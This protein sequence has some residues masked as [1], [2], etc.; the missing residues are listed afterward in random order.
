MVRQEKVSME[1]GLVP[2]L[3]LVV[4]LVVVR[5]LSQGTFQEVQAVLAA[6]VFLLP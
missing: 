5:G 3:T 1:V 4:V 6:Q 2:L